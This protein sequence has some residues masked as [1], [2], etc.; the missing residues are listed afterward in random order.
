MSRKE[1]VERAALALY[2]AAVVERGIPNL[3]TVVGA[4]S[5]RTVAARQAINAAIT[6]VDE[7]DK[8]F[9][10]EGT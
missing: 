7:M 10:E 6:F 8:Q 4:E 3:A 2:A 9:P 5:P 1:R